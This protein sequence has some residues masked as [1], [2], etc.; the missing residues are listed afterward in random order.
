M[1]TRRR[2]LF[3]VVALAVPVTG[4]AVFGTPAMFAGASA[5]AFPVACKIT[6][7]VAFSP[8]LTA[9]GTHTTS[10]TAVTT[11]TI[12]SGHLAACLSAAPSEAPGHG[13]FPTTVIKFPATKLGRRSYATG[14]CPAFDGTS[15]S[16]LKAFKGV[17][18]PITWTQ[19]AGGTSSFIVTKATSA[20]NK[21]SEVGFVLAGKEVIGSYAEKSLN[22]ITVFVD[23]AD[24]A[25]LRSSCAGAQTVSSVTFDNSNSVAIL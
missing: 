20:T 13:D 7:T 6:A 9:A 11:V 23:S 19:G 8:A 4:F 12:S 1:Q 3:G 15:T 2:I 17:K 22:Q 25:I 16:T 5:P 24:S 14:Y 10:A 18:L 21:D